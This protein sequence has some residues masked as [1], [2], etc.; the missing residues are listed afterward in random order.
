MK[1]AVLSIAILLFTGATFATTLNASKDLI[2]VAQEDKV[3]IKAEELPEAAQS[4][5]KGEGLK[6]WTIVQAYH[7]KSSNQYEVELKKGDETKT[8]K[9]DK[10]GKEI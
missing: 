2:S 1:K 5:L 10:D 3:A 4:S 7:I 8:V 9:F 6:D